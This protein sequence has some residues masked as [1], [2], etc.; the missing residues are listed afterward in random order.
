MKVLLDTNVILD[1]M[2]GR[3][4]WNE[5]A[6]EIILQSACYKI[7]AFM[8]ASTVTD[9]YYIARKALKDDVKTRL[10]MSSLLELVHVLAVNEE[11]CLLALQSQVRDFEDAVRDEVAARHR[12]DYII[13]R[14]I[15]DFE[16]G[17]V[18]AV[19][20]ADLGAIV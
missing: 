5:A 15:M 11:D 1:A 6:E 10:L 12:L 17:K 7:E 9:I 2:L 4:P 16:E 13:T 20:P 18:R 19:F 14:N 3:P 8:T